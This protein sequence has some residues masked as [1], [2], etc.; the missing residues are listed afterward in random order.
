[1][2]RNEFCMHEIRFGFLRICAFYG[3]GTSGLS[4]GFKEKR[5]E[6]WGFKHYLPGGV[7]NIRLLGRR[8]AATEPSNCL[9]FVP[10]RQPEPRVLFDFC[11]IPGFFAFYV[12]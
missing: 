4:F 9:A 5:L 3:P 10:E 6:I 11:L 7:S 2:M 12:R 1:M 8:I